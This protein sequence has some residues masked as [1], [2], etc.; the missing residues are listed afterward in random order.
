ML[1]RSIGVAVIGALYLLEQTIG[2]LVAFVMFV[3]GP[4]TALCILVA[5]I[6]AQYFGHIDLYPYWV[7][8]WTWITSF[9]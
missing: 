8:A 9:F 4:R 2:L 3:I 1:G 6:A 7:S 5:V